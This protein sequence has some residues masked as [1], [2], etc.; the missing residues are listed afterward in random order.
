MDFQT[1]IKTCFS[2]YVD[3]NGRAARSEYWWWALFVTVVSLALALIVD[4]AILGIGMSGTGPASGLWSLATL[5]PSIFVG[6]RRLHDVDRSGWWLL[7]ALIPLIGFLVLLYW[8]VTKGT[9]GENRFG[10]D[11]L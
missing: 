6:V 3:W 8:F 1:A 5:L 7:I 2:K 10:A 9:D 4:G 11:P